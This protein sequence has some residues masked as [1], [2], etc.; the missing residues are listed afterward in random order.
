VSFYNEGEILARMG[1]IGEA[2]DSYRQDLRIARR[3]MAA[4][5]RNEQFRGDVAYAEIRVGD[6]FVRR[7]EPA[8]ALPSYHASM[9]LR[10]E[11]V[12]VDSANIW[13]RSSLIEAHAKTAKALSLLG[14]EPA[15]LAEIDLTHAL[16]KATAIP[17]DEASI[18][19]FFADSYADLGDAQATLS[20]AGGISAWR[21]EQLCPAARELYRAA[22]AI[23]SDMASRKILSAPDAAKPKAVERRLQACRS[24]S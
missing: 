13:K 5:P 11:D 14:R 1:R 24:R 2:L 10:A 19:G 23:W 7:G 16:M 6:M 15:A 22:L 4:D 20:R 3:L 18:L 12:K 17:R 8:R 9:V 21:R